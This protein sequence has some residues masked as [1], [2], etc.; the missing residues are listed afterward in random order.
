MPRVSGLGPEH[1]SHAFASSR[2]SAA[3]R[4]AVQVRVERRGPAEVRFSLSLRG[5]GHAYPTGD[6]F[7]RLA[8]RVEALGPDFS[9]QAKAERFLARH[10]TDVL[11]ASQR[12][13][14]R[15]Q[16][17]DR[18]LP[19]ETREIDLDL[20]PAAVDADL[21]YEIRLERVLHMNP[22]F[23]SAA[24]VSSSELVSAGR[25]PAR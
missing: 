15:V 24:H 18:L 14:R 11:T 21:V 1:A 10:F 17:D 9:I 19:G 22:R 20:G 7:R 5:V 8:L 2:S 23:E 25:L 3:H 16:L 12:R 4:E 6:L 13:E